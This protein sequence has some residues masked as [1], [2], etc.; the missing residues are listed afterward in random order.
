M[1][2]H[3]LISQL[4]RERNKLG[5]TLTMVEDIIGHPEKAIRTWEK[6]QRKPR[7]SAFIDYANGLGFD[8]VLKR[9]EE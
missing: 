6:G 9:K 5:L 8:V 4:R 3:P 1:K 2:L 7:F